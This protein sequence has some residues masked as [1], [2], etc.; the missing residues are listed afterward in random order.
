[1]TSYIRGFSNIASSFESSA[2]RS[3]FL[4]NS[5]YCVLKARSL[6][7]LSLIP[8]TLS[9]RTLKPSDG[10]NNNALCDADKKG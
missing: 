9:R 5:S 8:I 1:M 3:K 4:K 2:I 7:F 10:G 6:S